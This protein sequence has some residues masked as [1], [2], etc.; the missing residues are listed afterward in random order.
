MSST[1]IGNSTSIQELFKRV[2]EQ[3]SAMFRRKAFLVFH[4]LIYLTTS[5]G[6]QAKVWTRWNSLRLKATCTILYP[7]FTS[8]SN[9]R[10]LNINNTRM[11]QSIKKKNMMR[12]NLL[13]NKSKFSRFKGQWME[14]SDQS[15]SLSGLPFFS[16]F[17]FRCSG[18]RS[19]SVCIGFI[20]V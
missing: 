14:N 19:R 5:I 15:P 4:F 18:D 11:P 8:L 13:R 20:I 1:F 3:F 9:S 16:T 2:G 10:L 7:H 17:F 6:T 12:S